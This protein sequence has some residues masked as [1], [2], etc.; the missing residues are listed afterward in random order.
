M[1]L[2]R[3]NREFGTVLSDR[4]SNQALRELLR[5]Y[6]FSGVFG[7]AFSRFCGWHWAGSS[8][9]FVTFGR[10]NTACGA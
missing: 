9:N 5:R 1:A 6:N 7:R 3:Q 10:P 8:D 4:N 2:L